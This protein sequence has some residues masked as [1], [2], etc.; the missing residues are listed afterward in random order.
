MHQD[1]DINWE[2]LFSSK[3]GNVIGNFCLF[4]MR[5]KKIISPRSVSTI[6]VENTIFLWTRNPISQI[7]RK[8][9]L[10]K[11]YAKTGDISTYREYCKKH[12]QIRKLTRK[13]K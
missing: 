7:R 3:A 6:E 10:W 2:R 5:Y 8:N 12:N 13:A 1:L 11:N 9:R 4:L